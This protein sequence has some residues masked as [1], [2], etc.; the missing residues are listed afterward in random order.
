MS[1]YNLTCTIQNIKY[2]AIFK[3]LEIFFSFR[4]QNKNKNAAQ[5]ITG[6]S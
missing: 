6:E 3:L 4:G 1:K 5:N 2:L